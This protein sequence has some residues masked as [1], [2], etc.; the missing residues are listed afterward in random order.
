MNASS[1]ITK[2]ESSDHES[3]DGRPTAPFLT[4]TSGRESEACSARRRERQCR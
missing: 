1:N 3:D 2:K 4:M